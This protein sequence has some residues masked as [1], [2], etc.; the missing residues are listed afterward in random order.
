MYV[1][2]RCRGRAKHGH[3]ESGS[4]AAVQ[5]FPPPAQPPLAARP[6]GPCQCALFPWHVLQASCGASRGCNLRQTV[7]GW[8]AHGVGPSR[9]APPLF[10]VPCASANW[11]HESSRGLAGC[12]GSAAARSRRRGPPLQAGRLRVHLEKASSGVA[13]AAAG[14]AR[15][16][17]AGCRPR[18][19]QQRP[20][21]QCRPALGNLHR[22]GSAAIAAGAA[23]VRKRGQAAAAA[24]RAGA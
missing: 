20:R 1:S 9:S 17:H 11:R 3:V 19:Q 24:A 8:L 7:S 15:G 14:A 18:V 2:R 22:R 6:R 12:S 5:A 13:R 4:L 10:C 23:L 21:P 16:P